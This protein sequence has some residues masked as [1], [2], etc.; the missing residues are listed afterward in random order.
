MSNVAQQLERWLS[1]AQLR[2][3]RRISAVAAEQRVDLYLVGGTVRD[4]LLGCR[5][6]DL[7]VAVVG[8]TDR[9]HETVAA[10]LGGEVTSR[11]QF[12]TSRVRSGEIDLDL[13]AARSESYAHPGALPDVR[14]GTIDDDLARRDFSVNAMA[15]SLAEDTWADLL[16]QHGGLRDLR[17]GVIRVLHPGSFVDDATRVFRA[18]R[19]AVRLG[20]EIEP[21]TRRLLRR[22]LGHVDGIG[23]DR[24]RHEFQ[25]VL[26]ETRW[27]DVLDL[28]QALGV[29]GAVHP[30][31]EME[32]GLL[33]RLRAVESRVTDLVAL[34][35]LVF[36]VP[37]GQ[38]GAVIE[39]LNMDG[40]WARVARDVASVKGV[41]GRLRKKRIRRGEL[42]TLLRGLAPAAIQ[43]CVLA[44]DQPLEGKRLELYLDE[45][46]HVRP[47]L[48]GNDL[49]A[50]GVPQGPRVGEL[51]EALLTARLEGLV[52]NREDEENYVRSSMRSG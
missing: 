41:S 50:L 3:L 21:E 52:S 17:G 51:L 28:A 39:R 20:F 5:P 45:L 37:T 33:D 23:G 12:G 16:D 4:V 34:A 32:T 18:V 25:R 10:E 43:G 40:R 6:A 46:R 42:F 8:T 36:S 44:T 7:D 31:L 13:V 26:A 22:D 27:P 35:V 38:M 1:T 24:V 11:S 19:Y 48:D 14:P 29:L 15:V 2:L 9:F 47:V 30:A 49:I